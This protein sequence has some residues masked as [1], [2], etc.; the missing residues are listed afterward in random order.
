MGLLLSFTFETKALLSFS[1][2]KA[3]VL[4]K[5]ISLAFKERKKKSLQSSGHKIWPGSVVYHI[6][7]N[8]QTTTFF[9]PLS[10]IHFM[11]VDVIVSDLIPNRKEY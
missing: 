9:L 2:E 1:A 6:Y 11:S 3:T 5:A 7:Q 4:T 10:D 8:L